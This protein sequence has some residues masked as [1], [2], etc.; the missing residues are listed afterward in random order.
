MEPNISNNIPGSL[1]TTEPPAN[2]V[3]NCSPNN[4]IPPAKP[5][6]R[7]AIV[8]LLLKLTPQ[9]CLSS[10]TNQIGAA[11]TS[12]ATIALGNF[13]STHIT[14]PLPPHNNSIPVTAVTTM[15][16]RLNNLSPFIAHQINS[17]EPAVKNRIA[18]ISNGGMP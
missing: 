2:M 13:C 17:N 8:D 12:I 9:L 14:A 18:P 3:S 1:D 15:L 5:T 6:T 7:P 11:E 10:N 4:R 16:F